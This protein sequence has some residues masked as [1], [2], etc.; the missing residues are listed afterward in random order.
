MSPAAPAG[1]K[2]Y[3]GIESSGTFPVEYRFTPAAKGNRHLVVVFANFAAPQ[4]YG[5]SNGVFDKLRAN[6]LW[7]RDKFDDHR[8][9]YLCRDMDFSLERS[10][11]ALISN[12]M[13]AL[14][15]TPDSV[16][17]WGS[18]KGGSAALHFGLKYGFR[19]IVAIAPQF[20]I[21]T[22]VRDVHPGV[23]RFMLGESVPEE[24]V[25]ALDALIPDLLR[26]GA[27]HTANI[28]VVSAAQDDQYP[29]QI[30][31]YLGL[32][33][34][35][36]NF[37]LVFSDSPHIADHTQVAGRNVPLLMG[38]VNFL[39]DGIAPRLGLVRNG[40]EEPDRDTSVLSSYLSATAMVRGAEFPPPVV[41]APSPDEQLHQEAVHFSGHAPGAARVSVWEHGKYIG[42]CDVGPDGSWSWELGRAWS[43]GKHPVKLYAVDAYGYQ[44]KRIELT[45][46]AVGGPAAARPAQPAAASGPPLATTG[47]GAAAPMV[48]EPI[49]HEQVMD[50]QV[51]FTGLATGAARVGFRLNGMPLGVTEVAQ[52]GGWT[53]DAGWAWDAGT[54]VVDVVAMNQAG[55]ESPATTVPF[56][57][58][59]VPAPAAYYGGTY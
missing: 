51:V 27:N 9:Y 19:N 2:Q 13:R 20:A 32:L 4:D 39:I 35:Y 54:H 47:P 42:Q 10:V 5:W 34:N 33:R 30:E 44:S 8:S 50:A 58:M 57:V 29:T 11:L 48:L 23:A 41:L 55:V 1:R 14:E 6:V 7:I 37:N 26:A 59:P 36:A 15:L 17:L 38:L 56:T 40:F 28:Y 21:G 12:V 49:A 22:Y 24:N 46:T 53:W 18:S 16:T 25:R 45:F 31:P 43:L 3:T 52:D